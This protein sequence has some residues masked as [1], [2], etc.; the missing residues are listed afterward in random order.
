MDRG[1]GAMGRVH[2]EDFTKS[3]PLPQSTRQSWDCIIRSLGL[4]QLDRF[5]QRDGGA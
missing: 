3:A 5:Q 1:V 2:G 4:G